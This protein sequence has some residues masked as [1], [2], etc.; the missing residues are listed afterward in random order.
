MQGEFAQSNHRVSIGGETRVGVS[1]G[2]T[3]SQRS[4]D[5]SLC[6]SALVEIPA[7]GDPEPRS[8]SGPTY[9]LLPTTYLLPPARRFVNNSVD[10]LDL[11]LQVIHQ[12]EI[13]QP[14]MKGMESSRSV[15]SERRI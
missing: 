5:L 9:H 6:L 14:A 4:A 2:G 3:L 1:P 11:L 8:P 7:P 12:G 10:V 15:T 13:S